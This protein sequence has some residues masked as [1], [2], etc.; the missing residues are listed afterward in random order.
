MS[1]QFIVTVPY[2]E[3][4][5]GRVS[6][7]V[8]AETAEDAVEKFLEADD[9][10]VHSMEADYGDHYEEFREEAEAEEVKNENYSSV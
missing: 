8:E 7:V 6:F 10:D 2:Q 3:M 9:M 4:V 1:K 5:F